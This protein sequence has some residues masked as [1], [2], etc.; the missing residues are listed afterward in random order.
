MTTVV[1][2]SFRNQAGPPWL[3]PCLASVRDWA[4][5]RGYAYRFEDDQLFARLPPWFADKTAASRPMAADLGRLLWMRDLFGDGFQRAIWFDADLLIFDPEHLHLPEDVGCAFGREIWIQRSLPDGLRAYRN[6][7]NAVALFAADSSML[8]FYIDACL[9]IV[10][11]ADPD[12]MAPQLVGPKLLTALHNI[13]GFPLIETVGALSPLVMTDIVAGGG[14]AL[15]LLARKS[16]MPLAAANL[17][18]SMMG[19]DYDGVVVDEAM[20]ERVSA[21][22]IESRGAVLAV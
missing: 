14:A 1:C 3:A 11:R 6:V 19:R 12:A 22:L 5:V 2:Q 10:E 7:H 9:S 21:I 18:A 17:C 4:E 16:G 13:V 8:D 20:L 15:D